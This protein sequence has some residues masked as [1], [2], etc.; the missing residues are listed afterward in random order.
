MSDNLEYDLNDIVNDF[1]ELADY[2]ILRESRKRYKIHDNQ[3]GETSVVEKK[4]WYE[5][6]LTFY[7]DEI[8]NSKDIME[9]ATIDD[10]KRLVGKVQTLY[11]GYR[12]A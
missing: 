9:G 12:L 8:L 4:F 2:E 5:K 6:I 11:W 10:Y 1:N 7:I 3:C